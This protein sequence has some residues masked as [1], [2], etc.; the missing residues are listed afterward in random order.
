MTGT[1]LSLSD[2]FPLNG[3]FGGWLWTAQ[4]GSLNVAILLP[5][6]ATFEIPAMTLFLP[7]DPG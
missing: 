6:L 5:S 1:D 2:H 7:V 3:D 4:F